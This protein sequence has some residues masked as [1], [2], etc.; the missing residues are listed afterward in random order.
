MPALAAVEKD[1][2]NSLLSSSAVAAWAGYIWH[3][4]DKEKVVKADLLGL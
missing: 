1:I 2:G 4:L 3:S